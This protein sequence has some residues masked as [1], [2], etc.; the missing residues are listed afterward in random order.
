[1]PIEGPPR[2]YF[3]T[4]SEIGLVFFTVLISCHFQILPESSQS[5]FSL[6]LP[7]LHFNRITNFLW[8]FSKLCFIY[9]SGKETILRAPT[10]K[11]SGHKHLQSGRQRDM[12]LTG[13]GRAAGGP[14]TAIPT[15]GAMG[16]RLGAFM[17]KRGQNTCW[18]ARGETETRLAGCKMMQLLWK[19]V[20]ATPKL[21]TQNSQMAWQFH[22]WYTPKECL[23]LLSKYA[24]QHY[25][26]WSKDGKNQGVH[27]QMS[28]KYHSARKRVKF[29]QMPQQ[30]SPENTVPSE[31][32]QTHDDKY[33]AVLL[34]RNIWFR[35][36]HKDRKGKREI[37]AYWVQFFLGLM[38]IL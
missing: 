32:S 24:Q 15:T 8:N 27:Q 37:L 4:L 18:W 16:T 20:G 22:S 25:S 23:R 34:I 14:T 19:R 1:M 35:Q 31:V 21:Y 36:I 17:K 38:K 5:S 9:I 6:V 12:V 26:K 33:Y 28:T 29:W 10:L 7:I 13:E 2:Q 11:E 3:G 30:G